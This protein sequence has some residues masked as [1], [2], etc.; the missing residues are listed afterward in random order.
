MTSPSTLLARKD[1]IFFIITKTTAF[2]PTLEA[3]SDN[4]SILN[5]LG[6]DKIVGVMPTEKEVVEIAKKSMLHTLYDQFNVLS[7][8]K[9]QTLDALNNTE[10]K[11]QEL[12]DLNAEI[13]VSWSQKLQNWYSHMSSTATTWKDVH[14]EYYHISKSLATEYN[15]ILPQYTMEEIMI[16]INLV[17]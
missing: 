5:D 16:P 15:W 17:K 11:D 2:D 4:V 12:E 9:T 13:A 3:Y 8:T 1:L 7:I 6:E 10:L 14:S